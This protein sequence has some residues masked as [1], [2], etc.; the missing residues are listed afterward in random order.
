MNIQ[1][2]FP[3]GFTGLIS[4]LSKG[5]SRVFSNTTI[6]KHQF[7]SAQPFL[8]SDSHISNMTAGKTIALTMWTFV[9]KVMSLFF[10][11]LSRFVI[12]LFPRNKCPLI[13]WLCS[14]STV[15]FVA[16]ENKICYSFSLSVC[17]EMMGPDTMI[18][19]F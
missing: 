1:G 7:F 10:N 9:S 16:Q 18:L 17:L 13:S 5:L 2:S 6:Q 19:A 15:I 12:T 8:W 14:S 3:S 4:L 11:M